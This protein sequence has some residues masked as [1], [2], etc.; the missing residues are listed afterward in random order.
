VIKVKFPE[1]ARWGEKDQFKIIDDEEI[2]LSM[3]Y[4]LRIKRISNESDN[5]GIKKLICLLVLR[6]QMIYNL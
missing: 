1:D 2:E 6:R 4:L 3:D 5:R